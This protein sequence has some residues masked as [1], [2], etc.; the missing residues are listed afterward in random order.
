MTIDKRSDILEVYALG[1]CTCLNFE[2]HFSQSILPLPSHKLLI[3]LSLILGGWVDKCKMGCG[4][5]SDPQHGST[6]GSGLILRLGIE[7]GLA[8]QK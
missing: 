6:D 8:T 1:G 2:A 3:L 5:Q 4:V 7:M